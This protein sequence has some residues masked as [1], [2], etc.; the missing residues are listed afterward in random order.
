ME[1]EQGSNSITMATL[2]FHR[3]LMF[4]EKKKAKE[5]PKGLPPKRNLADLP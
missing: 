1:T 2:I 5:I 3:I 4:E